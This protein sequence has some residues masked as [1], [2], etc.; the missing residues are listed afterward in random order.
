MKI[1]ITRTFWERS[2]IVRVVLT[3]GLGTAYNLRHKGK[4]LS[5]QLVFGQ[6]KAEN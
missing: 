6:W 5:V 4:P 2:Q 3:N 1:T